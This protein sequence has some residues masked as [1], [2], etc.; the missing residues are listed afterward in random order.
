MELNRLNIQLEYPRARVFRIAANL[1]L[2][3]ALLFGS[4]ACAEKATDT[5]IRTHTITTDTTPTY[6]ADP[7]SEMRIIGGLAAGFEN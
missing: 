3:A 1:G 7:G 5:T 4:G 2:S 6:S